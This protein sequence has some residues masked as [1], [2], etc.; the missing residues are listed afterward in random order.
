MFT[1]LIILL[2]FLVSA[3]SL[4]AQQKRAVLIGINYDYGTSYMERNECGLFNPLFGCENDVIVMQDILANRFAF[5]KESISQLLNNQATHDGILHVLDSLLNVSKTGDVVVLFYSGHGTQV[6]N[7]LS[8]ETDKT[9]QSLVP[10]DYCTK[11]IPNVIRDKTLNAYFR[12]F[13]DKQVKMTAI[14]DCCHSGSLSRGPNLTKNRSKSVILSY[15]TYD[16]RDS[17]HFP[18]P[19]TL[20]SDFMI[21]SAARSFEKAMETAAPLGTQ[22]QAPIGAFTYALSKALSQQSVNASVSSLFN[23]MRAII[24]GL[25][26]EQE[27]VIG[28][29]QSRQEQTLFGIE[30]GGLPDIVTVPV[31]K[32]EEDD[33]I[34]IQAGVG[35][36]L[37]RGCELTLFSPK[38]DTLCKL[39]VDSVLSVALSSAVVIKGDKKL[40]ESGS[41]VRVTRWA[42]ESTILLPVYVPDSH[43]SSTALKGIIKKLQSLFRS[44]LGGMKPVFPNGLKSIPDPYLSVFWNGDQA[45]IRAGNTNSVAVND[46]FAPAVWNKYAKKDSTVYI[47]L[48]LTDTIAAVIQQRL[49]LSA[50]VQVV[51]D[52]AQSLYSLFGR[53]VPDRGAAYGFR[54]TLYASADSTGTLPQMSD[55]FYSDTGLTRNIYDSITDRADKLYRLYHLQNLAVSGLDVTLPYELVINTADKKGMTYA[56]LPT[57]HP[58]EVVLKPNPDFINPDRE[59]SNYYMYLFSVSNDGSIKM[60]SP[61]A[62]GNAVNKISVGT[63]G[64]S[65]QPIR[66]FSTKT[67]DP[68][69]TSFYLLLSKEPLTGYFALFDNRPANTGATSRGAAVAVANPMTEVL[70]LTKEMSTNGARGSKPVAIP[71]YFQK[72]TILTQK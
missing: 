47:E 62:E 51:N 12:K 26:L 13:L 2:A 18:A 9:D 38:G 37:R 1:R 29:Q 23:S 55:C 10:W 56:V 3:V 25:A 67:D 33:S 7:S 72:I 31:I 70:G 22:A 43:I 16:S 59:E 48:P 27:P 21:V 66:L 39:L 30:K 65:M 28:A 8:F 5:P 42:K 49:A 40:L 63:D 41:L 54:K 64:S 11:G 44:G 24:K 50:G 20:S 46:P 34:Y 4:V 14:F 61:K 53:W 6:R 60:Q 57:N 36:G 52:P 15:N 32:K 19:E 17:S 45:Y 71:Y 58:L 69:A 68:G 35:I